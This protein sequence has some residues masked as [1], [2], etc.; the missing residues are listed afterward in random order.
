LCDIFKSNFEGS[1]F[2]LILILVICL[3]L[4]LF[5]L[6]QSMM[7]GSPLLELLAHLTHVIVVLL[8]MFLCNFIGQEVT[9]HYNQIFLNVYHVQWYVV[10]IYIQKTILFLLQKGT[11][12]YHIV[13]GGFFVLSMESAAT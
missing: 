3:S 6:L 10:P 1:F 9:D 11:K 13:F 4:N 7:F 2:S 5:G 8:F 12:S